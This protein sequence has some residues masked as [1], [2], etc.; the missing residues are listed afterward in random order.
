MKPKLL[1]VI[2]ST[3]PAR[4][5]LPVGRWFEGYAQ[6]GAALSVLRGE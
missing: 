1:I 5:G 2:A 4:V 6:V 3:R